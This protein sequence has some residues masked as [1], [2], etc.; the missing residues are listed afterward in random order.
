MDSSRGI[1]RPVGTAGWRGFAL[2]ALGFLISLSSVTASVLVAPT[3]VILSDKDNTGRITIQNPT[4]K[5]KEISIYMSF[6]LPVSDSTGNVGIELK[7]SAVTD[8]HCAMSWVKA[9]PSKMILAPNATQVI[10][11]RA[12]P[13]KGLA[14]GEYWARIVVKSQEGTTTIP[15]ASSPDK[16]STKLNMVMQTAIMLKYRT[17]NMISKLEV[18]QRDVQVVDSVVQVTVSMANRGNV[19]YVGSLNCRLI[20]AENKV[21]A[22]DRFDLAVYYDLTRRFHFPI[23][24]KTFSRPCKVEVSINTA[25]RTDL[26]DA[27]IVSGN[28]IDFSLAVSQ[29]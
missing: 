19:S 29:L 2:T 22:S 8:P 26:A 21:V 12:T 4:D 7:D 9:F 17:G 25:G 5:P 16:I 10:R 28:A 15:V 18:T 27:E 11:L 13:P 24:G 1:P 14:D 3:V 23:A 6:G 20:D